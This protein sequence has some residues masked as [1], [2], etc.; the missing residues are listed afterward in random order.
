MLLHC[1]LGLIPNE[2]PAF[3]NIFVPCM[4][5]VFSPLVSSLFT[6]CLN[7]DVPG[8]VS[9]MVPVLGVH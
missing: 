2:K 3:L 1:L 6:L 7:T 8:V 9:I 5:C 4:K